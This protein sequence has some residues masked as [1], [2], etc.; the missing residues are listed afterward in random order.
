MVVGLFFVILPV[1]II[2]KFGMVILNIIMFIV[3]AFVTFGT[4]NIMVS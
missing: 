1:F 2:L 4:M 3:L